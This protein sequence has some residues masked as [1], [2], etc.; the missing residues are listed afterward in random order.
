MT[1]ATR[2][3]YAG[4]EGGEGTFQSKIGVEQKRRASVPRNADLISNRGRERAVRR[5][6]VAIL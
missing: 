5:S 4:R 1:G 2:V 6:R 3:A